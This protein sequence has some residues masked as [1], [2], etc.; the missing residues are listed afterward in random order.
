MP[1]RARNT[2]PDFFAWEAAEHQHTL[3]AL[4]GAAYLLR[5]EL[6]TVARLVSMD[7]P[8]PELNGAAAA[9]LWRYAQV[10]AAVARYRAAYGDALL[11]AGP[12]L[13]P[14]EIAGSAGWTPP[15]TPAQELLLASLGSPG[16]G[17][18]E[19]TARLDAAARRNRARCHLA[20]GT[21][22]P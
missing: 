17:L 2:Q 22:R 21:G 10:L 1:P 3:A 16:R 12:G 8:G 15:L 5:A 13:G 9:A 14:Q 6:L 11:H 20:A 18:S 7:A 4:W 19:F